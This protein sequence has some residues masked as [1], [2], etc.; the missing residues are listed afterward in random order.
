VN[1]SDDGAVSTEQA[2]RTISDL[3]TPK[4]EEVAQIGEG[5][6]E[7]L[8]LPHVIGHVAN[9]RT[10]S[11]EAAG[12]HWPRLGVRSIFTRCFGTSVRV[13]VADRCCVARRLARPSDQLRTGGIWF[14]LVPVVFG[15]VRVSA[16]R[17]SEQFARIP[18]CG[19]ECSPT[20]RC[21][22]RR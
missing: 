2:H 21:A 12:A 18:K 7:P 20:G 8:Q 3:V 15:V 22:R 5:V 11:P 13:Q 9:A 1:E 6:R 14:K 16:G 4:V 17:E 10:M 19:C